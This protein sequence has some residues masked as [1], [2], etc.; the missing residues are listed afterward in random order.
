MLKV[1]KKV[2]DA[3]KEK[4]AAE[5][6]AK[7]AAEEAA[8]KKAAAQAYDSVLVQIENAPDQEAL[9]QAV[10]AFESSHAAEFRQGLDL[11]DAV[12]QRE[13]EL[14]AVRLAAELAQAS[15]AEK[16][17]IQEKIEAA[18]AA[19]EAA[20]EAAA[21]A[22]AAAA[23]QKS[24]LNDYDTK[25]AEI[26]EI[27][28]T[29]LL[30]QMLTEFENA[31]TSV[32]RV[33][34]DLA[35]K[36]ADRKKA[37]TAESVKAEDVFSQIEAVAELTANAIEMEQK[38]AAEAAAA[39]AQKAAISD[40]DAKLKSIKSA[41]TLET[42]EDLISQ[43]ESAHDSIARAG[44][45]LSGN[46]EPKRQSIL[47]EIDKANKEA[48][49]LELAQQL[50]DASEAEKAALQAEL[51][52][53]EAD[54]L[55]AEQAALEKAEAE[56]AAQAAAEAEAIAKA[57]AAEQEAAR[58]AAE[59]EAAASGFETVMANAEQAGELKEMVDRAEAVKEEK[60]A[61]RLAAQEEAQRLASELAQA[62]EEQKAE[63]EAQLAAAE[64]AKAE[65]EKSAQESS[66]VS[67]LLNN[68]DKAKDLSEMVR[69]ADELK[70]EK[71]AGSR[72]RSGKIGCGARS[73]KVSSGTGKSFGGRKS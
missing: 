1:V 58:I 23:A 38:A 72:Q 53:A 70:A 47:A 21:A 40:Y 11:S 12:S 44:L 45:D 54:R 46:A 19:E 64:A 36:V 5:E 43:F 8:A 56:A 66:N 61:E 13:S 15:E 71:E 34:L 37:I 48:K 30:D 35:A 2:D 9:N 67:G 18:K 17:A 73:S 28:D 24:A 51:D 32:S 27:S 41:T 16:L 63:L 68:A 65:A 50:A 33:G 59:Q 57:L 42:I 60:E 10:L 26:K 25:L 4:K 62:S 52:L 49:A 7:K 6:A 3:A 39:A 29:T 69:R 22:K 20:K 14:E 31:H 55:A